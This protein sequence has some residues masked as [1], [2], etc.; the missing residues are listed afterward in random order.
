MLYKILWHV[1]YGLFLL[2]KDSVHHQAL[3]EIFHFDDGG[4]VCLLNS[5]STGKTFVPML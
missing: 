4:S 2:L 1:A 3:S 5:Y